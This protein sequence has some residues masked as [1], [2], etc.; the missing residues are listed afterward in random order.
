RAT[1]RI[2]QHLADA[3]SRA[4]GDRIEARPSGDGDGAS[5]QRTRNAARGRRRDPLTTSRSSHALRD[6]LAAPT[7]IRFASAGEELEALLYLP[8]RDGPHPCV[9]MAGGW[10]Y[11]KE[12]TQPHFAGV[13]CEQGLA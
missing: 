11:V 7:T 1:R 13:F 2:D 4:R 6:K 3:R 8:P 9:V 12:L 10:C 5:G